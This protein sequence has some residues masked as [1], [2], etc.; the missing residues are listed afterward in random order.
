MPRASKIA[1]R[2]SSKRA[3]RKPRRTVAQLRRT[4]IHEAA[5]K[6]QSPSADY[7]NWPPERTGSRNAD[8]I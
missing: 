2:Q 3:K 7:D 5:R 4:A 6:L 8:Q 1:N